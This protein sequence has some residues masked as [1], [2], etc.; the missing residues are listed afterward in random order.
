MLHS[1]AEETKKLAPGNHNHRFGELSR[2]APINAQ[3]IPAAVQTKS[4]RR[5]HKSHNI[6][7]IQNQAKAAA[8]LYVLY[9]AEER[10]GGR[11]IWPSASRQKHKA[12]VVQR[13][14]DRLL[15]LRLRGPGLARAGVG[16]QHW[17]CRK[18]RAHRPRGLGGGVGAAALGAAAPH[19]PHRPDTSPLACWRKA[20]R[21]RFPTPSKVHAPPGAVGGLATSRRQPPRYLQHAPCHL[22]TLGQGSRT[23]TRHF[24]SL[25]TLTRCYPDSTTL[26]LAP[27]VSVQLSFYTLFVLRVGRIFEG[28]PVF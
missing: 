27:Q 7:I 11:V 19:R 2:T 12:A 21:P 4:R 26:P 15:V 17:R 1:F 8:E 9:I 5:R 6:H 28:F 22:H 24:D 10:S 20:R 18:S 23:A 3:S 13:A 25:S 14:V 16:G